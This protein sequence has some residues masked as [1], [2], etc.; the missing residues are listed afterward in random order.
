[1]NLM[2]KSSEF[3]SNNESTGRTSS[4]QF[5]SVAYGANFGVS[6]KAKGTLVASLCLLLK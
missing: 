4:I 6:P 1:M 3:L 5:G 2:C